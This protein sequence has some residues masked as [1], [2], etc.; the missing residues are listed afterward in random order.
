[1]IGLF[2]N[3]P[4]LNQARKTN[5]KRKGIVYYPEKKR[6]SNFQTRGAL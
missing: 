2:L 4:M 3:A 6:L 1:M 5:E